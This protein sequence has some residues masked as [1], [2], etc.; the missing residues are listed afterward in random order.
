MRRARAA[1]LVLIALALAEVPAA[2]GQPAAGSPSGKAEAEKRFQKAEALYRS[3]DYLAAATEY[4]AAY[5]TSGLPGLL[6]NVAQSYRL[7]GEKAKAAVAYR[8]FLER[9]PDHQLAAVARGHLEA[10][11]RELA[12]DKPNGPAT[13]PESEETQPRTDVV[14]TG[15]PATE[16]GRGLRIAGLASAGVGLIALGGALHYGIVARN[17]S[18]AISRNDEGWSQSLLDR[19]HEGERAETRMF[20]LS[21]VGAA[22]LA[23]G[24][25]LYFLGWR[26]GNAEPALSVAVPAGGSAA[27]ITLGGSF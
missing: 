22:A 4:Q 8:L 21:G 12:A 6:Y 2:H 26:A 1:A 13:R 10:L 5:D 9:A 18:D 24:G 23:A 19:Y 7:G 11:E 16:R 27:A 14:T 15:P 17:A 20:V 25:V 3:G